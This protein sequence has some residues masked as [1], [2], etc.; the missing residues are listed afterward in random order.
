MTRWK[1]RVGFG[2]NK[3]WRHK[4]WRHRYYRG[5]KHYILYIV[6]IYS[7][8]IYTHYSVC[9]YTLYRIVYNLLY[10]GAALTFEL[11]KIST[12]SLS[13]CPLFSILLVSWHS[14]MSCSTLRSSLTSNLT[15][16]SCNSVYLPASHTRTEKW[17]PKT[18][19]HTFILCSWIRHGV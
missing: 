13:S 10:I 7:V 2:G 8:Y 6:Y 4:I 18:W 1:V 3:E 14:H 12:R 19:D 17:Q 16:V 5:R 11:V 9:M 15:A